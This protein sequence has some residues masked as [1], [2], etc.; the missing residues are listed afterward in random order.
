MVLT[1]D[2][3]DEAIKANPK[4]LVEFYAPWCGHCKK[5]EPEYSG[6]A[7]VL[8]ASDPPVPLG[9][10][11]ATEN[12]KVAERFS[13]Q[14]F[15]TLFW[16]SN[17]EKLEYGGGRTKDTI[18]SWVLKKSGPPSA[19]V[20]CAALGEKIADSKF[21]VAYFGE[22]SDSLYTE[23]HVPYASSEDNIVFVHAPAECASEHSAA[24]PGIMFFRNFEEPKVAYTG[25]PDKDTLKAF[26]QPLTVP[27][28]FEFS[29][30]MIEP[31][32]GQQQSTLFLFQSEKEPT[33][34]FAD[35]ALANKG[36]VLFSYSGV[37]EGIQ[38]RLAEFVGATEADLPFMMLLAPGNMK[39]YRME[40]AVGVATVDDI[41]KFVDGV[42]AGD[43][44]P[45]LK[46]EEP[47]ATQEGVTVI[48]G[49]T[50]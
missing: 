49:T 7:E 22:E 28:V 42:L 6:A 33:P 48:V 45:H 3:F 17:G 24:A 43:I 34:A 4:M 40:Q 13:I 36:K 5:L 41:T 8:A 38:E 46:S 31:I 20:T 21:V 19:A 37:K 27:T 1:D 32:F 39:K 18:V 9:K 44:K 14:G 23:A 50:F 10:V 25:A 11:D 47:P 2:N 35:A 30:D 12:K 29:E 15:P 26:V 16:F